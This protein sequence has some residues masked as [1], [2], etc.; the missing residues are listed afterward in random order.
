MK[1]IGAAFV[2]AGIQMSYFSI[3]GMGPN[4]WWT[5]PF[6][7][8]LVQITIPIFLVGVGWEIWKFSTHRLVRPATESPAQTQ[9]RSEGQSAVHSEPA[10][11]EA[12]QSEADS[13]AAV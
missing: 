2:L 5:Y 10:P 4:W 1:L 12:V 6:Y 3:R 7:N 9:A 8:C 11:S 13:V